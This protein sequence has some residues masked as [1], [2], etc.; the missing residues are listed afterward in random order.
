[1]STIR[2]TLRQISELR[3]KIAVTE[4][5]VIHLKTHYLP[6]ERSEAEM[7]FIRDDHGRVP[8][9]HINAS[10]ADLVLYLDK[11][12]DDLNELENAPAP[13][14]EKAKPKI[15]VKSESKPKPKTEPKKKEAADGVAS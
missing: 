6:S 1:M 2:E 14:I 13:S 9:E 10:M 7:H 5:I 15:E 11:L 8:P 4:G 12:K 3:S